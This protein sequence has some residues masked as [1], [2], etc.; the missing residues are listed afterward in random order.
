MQKK[1]GTKTT[2]IAEREDIIETCIVAFSSDGGSS[3][4]YARSLHEKEKK[5]KK[6]KKER[7]RGD[8]DHAAG[9]YSTA[10]CCPGTILSNTSPGPAPPANCCPAPIVFCGGPI[11]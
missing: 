2:G 6:E 1:T 7:N 5:E 8:H 9:V 3:G 10:C 4:F 11:P